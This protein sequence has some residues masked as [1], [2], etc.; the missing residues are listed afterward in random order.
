MAP[1][2]TVQGVSKSFGATRALSG[3]QLQAQAGEIHAVIGENGAG[4]STLMRILAGEI[5][6]DQGTVLLDGEP[7]CVRS[8]ADAQKL[9]V[10]F[11]SQEIAVCPHMSVMD[12]VLLGQEPKRWG[13]LDRAAGR[14]E[15]RRALGMLTAEQAG[16]WLQIDARVGDLPMAGRQWVEIARAL[17]G[18][19]GCRVLIL[20]E[21]TSSLGREDADRLF[22]VIRK[23]SHDG[24]TVLYVSHFLEE[25]SAIAHRFTVLRDG[26]TVGSGSIA[27]T[28]A[29]DI[30][31]QMVGRR[32][33]Q[34]FT[35]SARTPGEV[36]LSVEQLAG[37]PKPVCATLQL[38][39]GEVLGVAGLVGAG[40]TELLRTLFG[41]APVR[42]GTIRVGAYVGPA[43]PT[44]RLQ[45]G[46]GLL[47]EDRKNEGLATSLSIADNL[48]LSRLPVREPFGLLSLSAQRQATRDWIQRLGIKA[49]D[50][51]QPVSDLSGGNQQKVALARLLHHGV[52]VLL[53]D[54]PTRGIDV[55]SKSQIYELIDRL[56]CEGKAILI[57]SSYLPELLGM[58]DR[59]QVMSRGR[60]GQAKNTEDWSAQTLL[61]QATGAGP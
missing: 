6:P 60:L 25:V 20:D 16:N 19:G 11:V 2:L 17:V 55:G 51:S 34:L 23:L 57:V 43:S 59:I 7:F 4:K 53:L 24:V 3:V 54:E 33:E 40:R 38:R 42:S 29:S 31:Q 48:T 30:V 47:S 14:Q 9:G 41:L 12:N 13:L 46:I 32:I 44:R 8:P 36:L 26:V 28:S 39:R 18:S 52:D 45:Q 1:R 22:A 15:V 58:C 5:S 56:A 10:S 27:E 50:P 49:T 37:F 61:Q 35:R 21:P